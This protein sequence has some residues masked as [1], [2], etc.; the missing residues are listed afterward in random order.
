MLPLKHYITREEGVKLSKILSS[1]QVLQ[2]FL[3]DHLKNLI[4]LFHF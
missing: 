2:G 1:T 3:N 4:S